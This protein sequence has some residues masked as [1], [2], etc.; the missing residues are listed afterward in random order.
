MKITFTNEEFMLM[1]PNIRRE[2]FAR[3]GFTVADHG[4]PSACAFVQVPTGLSCGVSIQ[5]AHDKKGNIT[6]AEGESVD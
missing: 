5:V 6:F 4:E 3:A 1:T 2:K